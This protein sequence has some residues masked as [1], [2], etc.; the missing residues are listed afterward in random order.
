MKEYKKGILLCGGTGSRL[1]D[2]SRITNKHMLPVGKK[3]MMQWNVEKLVYAGIKDILIV[4][5]KEHLG[6]IVT[7]FGGGSEFGCNFTYKVQEEAGGIAHALRLIDG[8]VG[9]GEFFWVVLG[10]NVSDVELSNVLPNPV[11]L[12]PQEYSNVL[13]YTNVCDPERFG[14]LTKDLKTSKFHIVEKPVNPESNNIVCGF[15]GYT[16]TEEF[17]DML[18]DLKKSDRGEVEIT[19]V[20][21][22]VLENN[23]KSVGFCAISG[24]WSDA[25]TLESYQNVNSWGWVWK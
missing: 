12:K 7:Y 19:D 16:Y 21:N 14:V 20:N 2:L 22:W 24:D 5:G 3:P 13:Y 1:K 25:G 6:D 23:P 17:K 15:Y 8:F 9:D 18:F 10:D 4:T 11:N